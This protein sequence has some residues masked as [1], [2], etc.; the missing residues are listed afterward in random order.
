MATYEEKDE[1]YVMREPISLSSAC[2]DGWP[3]RRGS[4]S[5]R[6]ARAMLSG[7]SSRISTNSRA[8]IRLTN[9]AGTGG[10]LLARRNGGE[11]GEATAALD[12]EGRDERAACQ[13][14][15]VVSG[16]LSTP[17][18]RLRAGLAKGALADESSGSDEGQRA[19]GEEAQQR[20]KCA[21]GDDCG[22]K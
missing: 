16:P 10:R 8:W 3:R 12:T 5:S 19:W 9:L 14:N 20:D 21:R 6:S 11:A 4:A 1:T 17:D 15:A 13:V 2:F 22:M 18:I 7:R